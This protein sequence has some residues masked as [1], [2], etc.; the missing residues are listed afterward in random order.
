MGWEEGKVA[1]VL[2]SLHAHSLLPCS[3]CK[4]LRDSSSSHLRL[5]QA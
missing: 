3:Q 1:M 5:F 4:A 2:P